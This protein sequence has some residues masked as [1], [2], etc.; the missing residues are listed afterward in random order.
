MFGKLLIEMTL[1][2]ITEAAS[3]EYARELCDFCETELK[4]IAAEKN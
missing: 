3:E 4:R 2:I 1:R